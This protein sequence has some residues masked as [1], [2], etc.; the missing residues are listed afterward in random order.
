MDV[1]VERFDNLN[2]VG[3]DLAHLLDSQPNTVDQ[4]NTQL[5]QLQERWDNLVH[6]MEHKSK[7]V[8]VHFCN[9][10]KSLRCFILWCKFKLEYFYKLMFVFL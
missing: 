7:E 6:L 2:D 4:I 10:S 5:Q 1:Q 8:I 3:Q 9:T